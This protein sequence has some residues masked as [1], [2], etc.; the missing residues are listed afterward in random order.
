VAPSLKSEQ[1]NNDS[2]HLQQQVVFSFLSFRHEIIIKNEQPNF[3]PTGMIIFSGYPMWPKNNKN[4]HMKQLLLIRH[5]KSS[6]ADA[7]MNDFDRPLNDRGKKDAPMMARRLL[8]KNVIIDAFVCSTANRARATCA[9]LMKE[10]DAPKEKLI[11]QQELYL[12]PPEVFY[13]CIAQTDNAFHTI[14]V[15]A[16]NPGI[17]DFANNLTSVRVDDMPTCAVYALHIHTDS[18]KDFAAATKEFWFFE[19][20]KK[21]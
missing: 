6:W 9:L 5:A 15:I 10:F 18:W 3:T 11:L 13:K 12:A 7:G 2:S 1:V 19:Y 20:P 8:S 21:P 17:T 4:E 14:A 16:H